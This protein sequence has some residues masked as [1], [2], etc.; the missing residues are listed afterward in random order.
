METKL[1]RIACIAKAKPKARFTS[2]VD[3]ID[4]ELLKQC[5]QE[6]NGNKS[7]GVD[8]VTKEKYQQNSDDNIRVLHQN[9][10]R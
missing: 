5:H 10:V 7:V 2:L 9:Y 4:E 1:T 6:L 3:L 8:E